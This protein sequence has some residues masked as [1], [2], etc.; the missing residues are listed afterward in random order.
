MPIMPLSWPT[1]RRWMA[2]FAAA[3]PAKRYAISWSITLPGERWPRLFGQ[4]MLLDKWSPAGCG[5]L[6]GVAVGFDFPGFYTKRIELGGACGRRDARWESRQTFPRQAARCAIAHRPQIH[7]VPSSCLTPPVGFVLPRQRSR[8][9]PVFCLPG[10]MRSALV[11]EVQIRSQVGFRIG[12]AVV[13]LEIDLFVLDA[14]PQ[15]LDEDVV[16]PGPLPSM[17]IRMSCAFRRPVKSPLVN[18]LP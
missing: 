18:G 8:S 17:L 13:G 15:A 14:F 11:V 10:T 5:R 4:E 6:T 2:I 9:R 7:G 12:N 16:P 1:S 3:W